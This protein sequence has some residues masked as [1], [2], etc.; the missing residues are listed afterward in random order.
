MTIGNAE[1]S[2][3][4][5]ATPPMMMDAVRVALEARQAAITAELRGLGVD[6][7]A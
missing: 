6:V 7:A 5:I 4:H 2:T 3:E 1:V